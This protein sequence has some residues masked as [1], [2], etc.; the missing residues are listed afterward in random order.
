MA[1]VLASLIVIAHGTRTGHG[2]QSRTLTLRI[3]TPAGSI[4]LLFHQGYG[5]SSDYASIERIREDAAK[6][7]EAFGFDVIEENAP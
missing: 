3:D 2:G 4:Y 1:I 7:S 5:S 6:L